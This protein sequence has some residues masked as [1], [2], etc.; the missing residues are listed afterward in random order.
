MLAGKIWNLSQLG[1]DVCR[2]RMAGR[3]PLQSI[4]KR[5]VYP[6]ILVRARRLRRI[7]KRRKRQRRLA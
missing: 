7:S 4:D 3:V 2:Q 5:R 1:H 6:T